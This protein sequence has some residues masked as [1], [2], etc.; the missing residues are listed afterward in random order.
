MKQLGW[1]TLLCHSLEVRDG[2]VVNYRLRQQDQKRH[3]VAALKNLNYHVIAAGDSFNDTAMLN[4]ANT[5]YFFCAPKH[6]QEQFPQFKAVEQ[7][8][9]LLALI[10]ADIQ[11]QRGE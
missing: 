5:G 2:S 1:P 4:E 6:I 11:R 10:K 9:D 8:A 3:A 7:H